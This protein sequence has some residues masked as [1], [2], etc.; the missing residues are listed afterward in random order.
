MTIIT[1]NE[2]ITQYFNGL[3]HPR[4]SRIVS[5]NNYLMNFPREKTKLANVLF[6]RSHLICFRCRWSESWIHF[7][8]DDTPKK[9]FRSD[10]FHPPWMCFE[11]CAS[12]EKFVWYTNDVET[13]IKKYAKINILFP[14]SIDIYSTLPF[15]HE[16]HIFMSHSSLVASL[17]FIKSQL[18]RG[19][20]FIKKLCYKQ[21]W[22]T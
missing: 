1:L 6:I 8:T 13:S 14:I 17:F 16:T 15:Y 10:A 21:R 22:K 4:I 3:S 12:H 11:F 19:R 9:N 20:T 18:W 2:N 7:K 5:Q